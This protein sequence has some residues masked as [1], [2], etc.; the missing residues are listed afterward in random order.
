MGVRRKSGGE[1]GLARAPWLVARRRSTPRGPA[2]PG[3][4]STSKPAFRSRLE[5]ILTHHVHLSPI[6][7]LAVTTVFLA[8]GIPASIFHEDTAPLPSPL[9]GGSRGPRDYGTHRLSA[10]QS[11]PHGVPIGVLVT[12]KDG[13][14]RLPSTKV[15]QVRDRGVLQLRRGPRPELCTKAHRSS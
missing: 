5:L 12:G 1:V 9:R 13:L 15:G 2:P 6:V 8:L 10:F 7:S 14:D 4:V 3:P 11:L